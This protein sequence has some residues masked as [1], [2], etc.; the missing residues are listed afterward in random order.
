MTPIQGP[1]AIVTCWTLFANVMK[2]NGAP[3][4]L[5]QGN[6]RGRA[7]VVVCVFGGVASAGVAT[8]LTGLDSS[9]PVTW[10][11]VACLTPSSCFLAG[12]GFPPQTPVLAHWDGH[13]L[14]GNLSPPDDAALTG[15]AC[16]SATTCFAV[17]QTGSSGSLIEQWDGSRW[18]DVTG[19]V[20]PGATQTLLS[21]VTCPASRLCFAVGQT[22]GVHAGGNLV[23]RW[24]GRR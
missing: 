19:P 4:E 13:V 17:G 12:V 7:G 15:V 14:S 9:A 16:A 23:E 1:A 3:A 20:R 5:P 8:P 18:T 2:E 6:V 24:D 21:G 22:L 11:A 10:A